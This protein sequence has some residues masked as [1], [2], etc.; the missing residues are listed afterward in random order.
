M[1]QDRV[2]RIEGVIEQMNERLGRLEQDVVALR[3]GHDQ[4]RAETHQGLDQ[5]RTEMH[6]GHDQLRTEMRQGH[7]SLRAEIRNNLLWML[8][9]MLA[10]WVSIIGVV[11]GSQAI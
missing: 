8:G 10:M 5:L 3:Q 6:Q 9:I 7:D 11:I 2:S 4:L 1:L